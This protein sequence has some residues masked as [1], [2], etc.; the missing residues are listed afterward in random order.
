MNNCKSY[1][2]KFNSCFYK[3]HPHFYQFIDIILEVQSEIY[4]KIRNS[5]TKKSKIILEKEI[6]IR[7]IMNKYSNNHIIKYH[8]V[9]KM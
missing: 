6:F 7:E 1:H 5:S 9:K 4:I 3:G 2:S 8:F